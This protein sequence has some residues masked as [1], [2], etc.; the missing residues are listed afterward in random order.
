MPIE[1]IHEPPPA[2]VYIAGP[3][4]GLPEFNYPAFFAAEELLREW[5]LNPQN[6]ARNPEQENWQGYM[7]LAIAMLMTCEAIYLLPGWERSPGALIEHD[8][9]RRCG[10]EVVYP[11]EW[12]PGFVDPW[13]GIA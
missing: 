5:G 9:A 13:E 8:L 10:L 4:S 3:M 11:H 6:P 7:K 1:V 12:C 2:R